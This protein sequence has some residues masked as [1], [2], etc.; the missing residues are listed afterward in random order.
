MDWIKLIREKLSTSLKDLSTQ[1]SLAIVW[2]CV[3][4]IVA[5]RVLRE[6]ALFLFTITN[7]AIKKLLGES[8]NV[9]AEVSE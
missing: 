9:S 5:W 4:A 3:G 6:A 2:L 8:N 7:L 1:P